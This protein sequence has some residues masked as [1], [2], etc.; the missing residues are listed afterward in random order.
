MSAVE[1]W[2]ARYG[3]RVSAGRL[4]EVRAELAEQTTRERAA[5]GAGDTELMRLCAAQ[6]FIAGALEDALLIWQAKTASMDA[7]AG[8]EASLL[9]G[10]GLEATKL[11]LAQ[12]GRELARA[13]LARLEALERA[14]D[15][16]DFDVSREVEDLCAYY[17]A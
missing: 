14:G 12:V 8:I 11:H 16:Q 1:A 9:C 6:L 3:L 10:G 5:Q 7:D 13:A 4:P 2:L 15:L 17:A